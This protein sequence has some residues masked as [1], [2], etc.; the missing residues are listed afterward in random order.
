MA[1]IDAHTLLRLVYRNTALDLGV[2]LDAA[3]AALRHE[4]PVMATTQ[5][6]LSVS[7]VPAHRWSDEE[8]H[9]FIS[10]EKA[11]EERAKLAAP[12]G[13]PLVIDQ[14]CV[15]NPQLKSTQ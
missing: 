12:N 14:D 8:L 9:A 15:E 10:A 3:K 6:D 5:V 11:K 13:Q 4:T 1:D 2:R 7:N